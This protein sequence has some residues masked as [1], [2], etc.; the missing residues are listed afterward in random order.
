MG[1]LAATRVGTVTAVWPGNCLDTAA[2]WSRCA[3]T[4]AG[5]GGSFVS[6]LG[7]AARTNRI[8]T[9][10]R[11]GPWGVCGRPCGYVSAHALWRARTWGPGSACV[12]TRRVL[13]GLLVTVHPQGAVV[14]SSSLWPTSLRQGAQ[15]A[16]PFS[17]VSGSGRRPS[18]HVT[19]A[20]GVT[21]FT[22]SSCS[23]LSGPGGWSPCVICVTEGAHAVPAGA[24]CHPPKWHCPADG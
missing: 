20:P 16:L 14:P 8:L 11:W 7:T 1:S 15:L 3:P 5:L 21:S 9:W 6:S 23:W 17:L 18:G 24:L 2:L 22:A 4:S 13:A 19:R 10:R 12:C